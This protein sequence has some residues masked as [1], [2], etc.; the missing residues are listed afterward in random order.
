MSPLQATPWFHAN[1]DT[2]TDTD[3]AL[4]A[5]VECNDMTNIQAWILTMNHADC[6]ADGAV[7]LNLVRCGGKGARRDP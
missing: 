1:A 6:R 4:V 7:P 2:D 5:S 3:T